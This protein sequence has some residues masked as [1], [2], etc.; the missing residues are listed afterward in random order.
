MNIICGTFRMIW[1]YFVNHMLTFQ[2]CVSHQYT[3]NCSRRPLWSTYSEQGTPHPAASLSFL[4][5]DLSPT[6]F[7]QHFFLS[8]MAPIQTLQTSQCEMNPGTTY[9]SCKTIALSRK[10]TASSLEQ[11]RVHHSQMSKTTKT[12][13]S[14]DSAQ[15]LAQPRHLLTLSCLVPLFPEKEICVHTHLL[16]YPHLKAA[17][18]TEIVPIFVCPAPATAPSPEIVPTLLKSSEFCSKTQTLQE[19]LLP[20]YCSWV[21]YSW[22]LLWIYEYGPNCLC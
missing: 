15:V 16:N 13:Q 11:W 22:A 8:T 2:V 14:N 20:S 7:T 1:P 19:A 10:E 17:T 4:P 6:L 12:M 9:Q 5:F 3:V 18:S 21:P